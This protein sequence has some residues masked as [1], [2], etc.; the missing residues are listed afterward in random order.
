M[1]SLHPLVQLRIKCIKEIYSKYYYSYYQHNIMI[2]KHTFV[3]PVK[4]GLSQTFVVSS[5]NQL[6]PHLQVCGIRVVKHHVYV[7]REFCTT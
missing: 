7:K 5:K 4:C 3:G 1:T 2:S 6:S